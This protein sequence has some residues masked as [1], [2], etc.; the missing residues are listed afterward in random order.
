MRPAGAHTGG[1]VSS[2]KSVDANYTRRFQKSDWL[3]NIPLDPSKF[4]FDLEVY[5]PNPDDVVIAPERVWR[6]DIF[7]YIDLG[8]KSLNMMQRP[9]VSMIVER[10]EVPVGF[11]TKGPDNR[12]IIVEGVGDLVLRNGK[13]L[14]CIKLRRSDTSGLEYSIDSNDYLPPS[15]DV[16]GTL[17]AG[18][19]G[20]SDQG[21]YSAAG[22]YPQGGTNNGMAPSQYDVQ[23]GSG[24]VIVPQYGSSGGAADSAGY[25]NNG[26]G[27]GFQAG[28]GAAN[29]FDYSKM[30]RIS[31][32]TNNGAANPYARQYGYGSGFNDSSNSNIS[33]ELGTDDNVSTLE[34]LWD[35]LS[36]KYDSDLSRYSPFFS[37]DAPA[38]GQGK[39]LFHLRIGPV[40]TLEEGDKTCS[41][42]GRNGVFCSVV[43][44]Q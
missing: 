37:V 34:K 10:M 24:Q 14:I 19:K 31:Y 25:G 15:W 35:K 42:L 41:I 22:G 21:G 33:I 8:K 39:E 29:G 16:S 7:T 2:G 38:D 27:I 4:R 28:G 44:T 30:Q 32:D 12:L 6:D 1:A 5:V 43:R 18:S 26:I 9:V 3:K 11:R 36:S 40:K 23:I 13:R 17:P 20:V